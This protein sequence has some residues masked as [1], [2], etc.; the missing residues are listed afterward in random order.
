MP[1]LDIG[2]GPERNLVQQAQTWQCA[3]PDHQHT[4]HQQDG[5]QGAQQLRRLGSD[6]CEVGS[7]QVLAHS[8]D[9]DSYFSIHALLPLKVVAL[10][11][12]PPRSQRMEQGDRCRSQAADQ[13]EPAEDL[14]RMVVANSRQHRECKRHHTR[15][16]I[17]GILHDHAPALCPGTEI[18]RENSAPRP[19]GHA[20]HSGA[21]DKGQHMG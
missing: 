14:R 10:I 8:I 16:H 12:Q 4:N 17:D 18:P 20:D 5:G 9:E 11:A 15:E 2:I 19:E 13:R 7:V 3:A 21:Y 1:L 6:R